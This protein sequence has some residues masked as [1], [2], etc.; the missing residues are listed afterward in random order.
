MGFAT[1]GHGPSKKV[2]GC[3]NA[4]GPQ[5]F[6]ENVVEYTINVQ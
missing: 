3:I 2:L 5:N 1:G 4:F 6:R